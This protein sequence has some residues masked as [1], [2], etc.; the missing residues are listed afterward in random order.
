[1]LGN[2]AGALHLCRP[3]YT[4]GTPTPPASARSNSIDSLGANNRVMC[5]RHS[6]SRRWGRVVAATVTG[7]R[8]EKGTHGLFC[9]QPINNLQK[10]HQTGSQ[11]MRKGSNQ[12]GSQHMMR[13]PN[14]TGPAPSN[15]SATT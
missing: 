8:G 12:T 15:K 7:R 10:S 3:A 14:Q 2:L 1:M 13:G 4:R 11:Q 5:R 9:D 6:I